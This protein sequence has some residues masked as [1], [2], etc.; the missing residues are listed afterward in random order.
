MTDGAIRPACGG[1]SAFAICCCITSSPAS[2]CDGSRS[3]P[4]PG[5]ARWSSGWSPRSGSSCRSCSACSSCRRGIREEGGIY[6][7]SKRAF[8]PF[9]A[10]ITGWTYWGS[11]LPYLPG[12]LYFAAANALFMGG[13]AWQSWSSEQHLLHRGRDDRPRDRRRDE[14]RRLERRQMADQRRR[15]RRLDPGDAADGARRDRVEPV[16][17]GDADHRARR[18]A[19]HAR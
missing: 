5:R 2:A 1:C 18:R 6:V 8:G 15:D 14:R 9:A 16:R 12:L 17:I 7:W 13:P 10:F 4:R 3:P 11:N 19:E